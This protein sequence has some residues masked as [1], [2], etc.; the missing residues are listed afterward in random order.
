MSGAM[1]AICWLAPMAL[2]IA[3]I[4]QQAPAGSVHGATKP[5]ALAAVAV[6]LNPAGLGT[7]LPCC[8]PSASAN[9][10]RIQSSPGAKGASRREL[11]ALTIRSKPPWPL[12]SQI[13]HADGWAWRRQCHVRGAPTYLTDRTVEKSIDPAAIVGAGVCGAG[14]PGVD[15]ECRTA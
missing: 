8:W 3:P 9:H 10:V 2:A 4:A 11:I 15:S 12:L 5:L 6:P 1:V 7:P 14:E 13:T